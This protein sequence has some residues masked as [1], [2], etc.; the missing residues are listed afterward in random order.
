MAFNIINL[1]K[2]RI[3]LI[4]FAYKLYTFIPDPAMV[5]KMVHETTWQDRNVCLCMSDEMVFHNDEQNI[6]K[7]CTMATAFP[8]YLVYLW[9][10]LWSCCY[11]SVCVPADFDSI[12]HPHKKYSRKSGSHPYCKYKV[13]LS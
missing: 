3:S 1:A 12:Q 5:R 2:N 8:P 9:S 7:T 10:F 6:C 13:R 11:A 4:Y